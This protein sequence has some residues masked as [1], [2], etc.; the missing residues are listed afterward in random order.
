MATQRGK[1]TWRQVR[2]QQARQLPNRRDAFIGTPPSLRL[3]LSKSSQAARNSLPQQRDRDHSPSLADAP[4]THQN[5]QWC[6]NSN[7]IIIYKLA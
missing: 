2:K 7:D 4:Q 6:M 3:G 1:T 5:F